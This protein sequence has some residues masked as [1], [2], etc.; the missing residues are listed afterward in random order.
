MNQMQPSPLP[1]SNWS[2]PA[3]VEPRFGLIS[4]QPE[5]G[6][7]VQQAAG[8]PLVWMGFAATPAEV[9]A[10]YGQCSH[11]ILDLNIVNSTEA[12]AELLAPFPGYVLVVAQPAHEL[13]VRQAVA[14]TP[15]VNQVVLPEEL[16][17]ALLQL[18]PGGQTYPSFS[19][20]L[21]P[22]VITPPP[23]P[24]PVIGGWKCIA[25]W[26]L[27]GG[28]GKTRLTR[29]LGQ[30]CVRR[31]QRALAM[32]LGC[33]D[34]LPLGAGLDPAP[35][36]GQWLQ[37]P[38]PDTLQQQVQADGD[39]D[40]LAGFLSPPALDRFAA[41]ALHGETSLSNLTMQTAH[42]GYAGVLLDVSAQEL[43]GPALTCCNS[44]VLLGTATAQGAVAVVEA[45]RMAHQEMGVA[46]AQIHLVLNR[47]RS[48]HLEQ[49]QFLRIVR[50]ALK[51]V[52]APVVVLA[53]D[54][55]PDEAR[56][57]RPGAP[58]G[59]PDW[60]QSVQRV[61]DLLFGGAGTVPAGTVRRFGPLV[62]RQGV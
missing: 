49:S 12:L 21:T 1:V 30:D 29:A 11:I 35:N 15:G 10:L 13:Q 9:P 8:A 18:R 52:P 55:T 23:G 16:A 37:H 25:V 28:V 42:L 19:E 50:T 57:P 51:E 31:G 2:A 61:G 7:F 22:Q 62:F 5:F 47:W 60:N 3:E 32:G 43:A 20:V 58:W 6:D 27:E 54:E 38:Q 4:P 56:T 59:S 53:E 36:L 26:G 44:L 45:F 39:L 48:H 46:A 33:P 41:Q 17:T 40:L 34:V 14:Q 24:S